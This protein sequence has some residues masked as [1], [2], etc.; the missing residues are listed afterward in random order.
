MDLESVALERYRFK[1]AAV[2]I[3][4]S[5]IGCT[6]YRFRMGST[7]D[8]DSESVALERYV[9]IQNR[10]HWRDTESESAELERYGIEICGIWHLAENKEKYIIPK[11]LTLSKGR[12]DKTPG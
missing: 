5:K 3:Y 2:G 7:I 4:G 10:L 8:M 6:G 12:I 9:K 1:S 11:N